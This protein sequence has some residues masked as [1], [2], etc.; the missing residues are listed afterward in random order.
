MVE[1]AKRV[2]Q[3]S[4]RERMSKVGRPVQEWRW[5]WS[6]EITRVES[7]DA[8]VPDKPFLRQKN[9]DWLL[10][11]LFLLQSACELVVVSCNEA[12]VNL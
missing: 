3:L 12:D 6:G 10:C 7:V 11:T 9:K 2:W 1:R 4:N 5:W 8:I